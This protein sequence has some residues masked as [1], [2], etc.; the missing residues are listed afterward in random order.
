MKSIQHMMTYWQLLS[1]IPGSKLKL[2]KIDDDI[3]TH[4]KEE[5]PDFDPAVPID[6]DHMKSKVGKEK[7]RQFISKYENTVT[8]YNFGTMLRISP[9]TEYGEKETIF[10]KQKFSYK[11]TEFAS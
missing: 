3:Y 9:K 7:W 6:E 5:F 2:T 8:D 1:G 11:E 10:G 4:F